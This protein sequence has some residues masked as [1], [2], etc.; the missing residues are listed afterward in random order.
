MALPKEMIQMIPIVDDFIQAMIVSKLRFLKERP[1]LVEYIFQ[2]GNTETIKRLQKLLTTQ[3]IRVVI[4]F[5]REQSTL[6]A[7]VITLAP[8]QEQPSGLGDNLSIYG[9]NEIGDEPD[10]IAQLFLDDYIASTFMNATYRVECW[11]DNGDL[12]A[13]MYA[14]LKWC[15]W[16]SRLEMLKMGWNNIRVEGTDLEP[17]PDYMP[18]FIYRRAAQLILTYDNMYQENLNNLLLYID[19]VTH[20]QNYSKDKDGNIIDKD[21]TIV[22]PAKHAIVLNTYVYNRYNENGKTYE[23]PSVLYSTQTAEIPYNFP[24]LKDF[25]EKGQSN[26]LYLKFQIAKDNSE[27]YRAYFWNSSTQQYESGVC[28]L[29]KYDDIYIIK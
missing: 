1:K 20:P 8:E 29:A 21:G 26:A 27:S 14:I 24:T 28:N 4:G 25:P 15:L 3:Q 13:Y 16:T 17:V 11:S 6:P 22:I 9:L 18:I 7:Y 10:E 12:T 23:T 5:P 19:I 2:T